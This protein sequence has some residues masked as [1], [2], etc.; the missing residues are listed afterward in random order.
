[1]ALAL[2]QGADIE[3]L[4]PVVAAWFR[5]C[6]LWERKHGYAGVLRRGRLNSLFPRPPAARD[7]IRTW[8][9]LV[10]YAASL[11]RALAAA[12]DPRGVAFFPSLLSRGLEEFEPDSVRL[13]CTEAMQVM[14]ARPD[15]R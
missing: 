13:G 12:G 11:R 1:M 15:A 9:P 4:R 5:Q 10:P 2:E 7:T 8:P 3:A 14:M 6:L